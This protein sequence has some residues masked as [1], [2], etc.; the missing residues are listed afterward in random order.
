M[1][2]LSIANFL[3][4]WVTPDIQ[5]LT[6]KCFV[7][8]D[9]FLSLELASHESLTHHV[10]RWMTVLN[11]TIWSFMV[12]PHFLLPSIASVSR[13]VVEVS[14]A[15]SFVRGSGEAAVSAPPCGHHYYDRDH[16]LGSV[17]LGEYALTCWVLTEGSLY[18]YSAICSHSELHSCHA[19]LQST[20]SSVG[21][22][23]KCFFILL[24]CIAHTPVTK[25][26]DETSPTN[27][28]N[29][30]RLNEDLSCLP[31]SDRFVTHT[32]KSNFNTRFYHTRQD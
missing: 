2:Y 32:Q 3:T 14:A 30:R 21:L 28:S 9:R 19:K 12:S 1:L 15:A 22:S 17:Q 29:V 26:S 23:V 5:S 4:R 31:V 10:R 27:D 7:L 25:C 20:L 6:C 16:C 8:S 13:E 24:Q 18:L 11:K